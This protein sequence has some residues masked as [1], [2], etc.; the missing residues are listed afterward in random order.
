MLAKS[1]AAKRLALLKEEAAR[2]GKVLGSLAGYMGNNVEYIWF[3]G[4]S[5]NENYSHPRGNSFS[6]A[7]EDGVRIAKLTSEIRDAKDQIERLSQHARD[8]GLQSPPLILMSQ[9]CF[10][11]VIR[12]IQKQIVISMDNRKK[13]LQ[14]ELYWRIIECTNSAPPTQL[15]R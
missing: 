8:L 5:T 1:A 13:I 4:I 9:V 11:Q 2:I 7:D 14:I 10:C 3:D 15:N 12:L 6:V